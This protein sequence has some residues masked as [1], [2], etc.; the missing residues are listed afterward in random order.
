[1]GGTGQR[2]RMFVDGKVQGAIIRRILLHWLVACVVMFMYL[3]ALEMLASGM[4]GSL[5]GHLKAMWQRYAPLL[6]AV[7]TLFPVFAYDTVRISHRFAGPM[8]S[9]K[10]NLRL[11]A[12]KQAVSIL[13]F[14]K[15]DFW[16]EL[17]EDLN[18]VAEHLGLIHSG[19]AQ[20]E[21]DTRA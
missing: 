17:T 2:K 16:H 20:R 19:G 4:N 6:V 10:R 15:G 14:R 3:L 18:R 11:M 12:E 5:S 1:M 9:L 21:P 7:V 13:K 8:V